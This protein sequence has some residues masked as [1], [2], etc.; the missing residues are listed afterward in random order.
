MNGKPQKFSSK[1][2]NNPVA[3]DLSVICQESMFWFDKELCGMGPLCDETCQSKTQLISIAKGSPPTCCC[4]LQFPP[5][6]PVPCTAL[7]NN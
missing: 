5:L 6:S 2:R 4:G 7:N 3:H 1:S